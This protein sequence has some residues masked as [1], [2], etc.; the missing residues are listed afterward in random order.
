MSSYKQQTD[1]LLDCGAAKK[2]SRRATMD[3]ASRK[4]PVTERQFLWV[5]DDDKGEVTVHVG[6][7]MVS[8]AAADR[9]VVDDA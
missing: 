6:P 1:V 7:T 9:V 5:Q 8:P 2:T 4:F 3:Q